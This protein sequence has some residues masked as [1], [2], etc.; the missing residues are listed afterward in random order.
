MLK[1]YYLSQMFL[2]LSFK[3]YIFC[4]VRFLTTLLFF[5]WVGKRG[6]TG[7][8]YNKFSKALTELEIFGKMSLQ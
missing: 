2:F 3:Y 8:N 4:A 7:Q 1:I 6:K 5:E